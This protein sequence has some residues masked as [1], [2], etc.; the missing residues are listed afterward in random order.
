MQAPWIKPLSLF[1]AFV[2][3]VTPLI[4]RLAWVAMEGLNEDGN[5][6]SAVA[7]SLAVT[8]A[9]LAGNVLLL[10]PAV[11]AGLP[12]PGPPILWAVTVLTF[13]LTIGTGFFSPVNL[14]VALLASG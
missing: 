11:A 2:L 9:I 3:I 1:A 13:G 14:V 6:V 7:L 10:R 8:L 5:L 4:G 12:M